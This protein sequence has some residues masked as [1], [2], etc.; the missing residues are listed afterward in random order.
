MRT[1]LR[2]IQKIGHAGIVVTEHMPAQ[3]F[4]AVRS[5]RSVTLLPQYLSTYQPG[6]MPHLH[7]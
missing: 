1:L 6:A 7:V 2:N 3:E 5:K 4:D